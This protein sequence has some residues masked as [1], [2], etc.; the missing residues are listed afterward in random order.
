MVLP[1]WMGASV[2]EVSFHNVSAAD[3]FQEQVHSLKSNLLSSL[4]HSF[5]LQLGTLL[6]PSSVPLTATCPV[7]V[8][9]HLH[10]KII[11]PYIQKK[12]QKKW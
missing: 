4:L 3:H 10:S 8:C 2:L 11:H 6:F 5:L 7:S 12:E 9:E 1:Q